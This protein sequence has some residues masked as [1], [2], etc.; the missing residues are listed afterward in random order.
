MGKVTGLLPELVGA[1]RL[2]AHGE[3]DAMCYDVMLVFE[4]VF[5]MSLGFS[6]HLL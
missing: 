5:E 1:W 6:E 2:E 3:D 4:S